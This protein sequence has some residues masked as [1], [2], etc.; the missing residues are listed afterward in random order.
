MIPAAGDPVIGSGF[1][2]FWISPNV[3]KFQQNMVGYWHP[4]EFNEAHDGYLEV[5]LELGWVGV[6]LISSILICGY[7]RAIGA[8]RLN[9]SIGGLML[10]Y[11]IAVAVYSIT[12]AGFRELTPEWI[13]LL[14]GTVGASGIA[15]GLPGNLAPNNLA[16]RG[17]TALRTLTNDELVPKRKSVYATP[18]GSNRFEIARANNP[19]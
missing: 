11:V 7:W 4:E 16:S 1:E 8:F 2:G 5:Y 18:R 10:A 6:V 3:L 13:F 14:L 12:E 17:G 9:S 15:A 19:R